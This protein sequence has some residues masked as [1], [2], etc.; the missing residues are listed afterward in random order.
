MWKPF[1]M[2][3][4]KQLIMDW[5]PPLS[6]GLLTANSC[7][8]RACHFLYWYNHWKSVHP[9]TKS[10]HPFSSKQFQWTYW[11]TH[12]AK[13]WE[14]QRYSLRSR[15]LVG[16]ENEEKGNGVQSNYYSLCLYIEYPKNRKMIKVFL[17][18]FGNMQQ[19]LLFV[20]T[21]L[22]NGSFVPKDPL[23]AFS[24]SPALPTL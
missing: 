20:I 1:K 4:L 17:L 16:R 21:F 12:K 3:S 23:I 10:S 9:P 13:S 8:G 14:Y 24:I 7:L 6:E 18:D 22:I 2:I 15:I 5:A 11:I 19:R